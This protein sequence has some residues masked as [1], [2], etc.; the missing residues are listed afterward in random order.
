MAPH[1]KEIT[2][3]LTERRFQL[4]TKAG[5]LGLS[6]TAEGVSLAGVPLL[7]KTIAGLAPR[8]MDELAVLIKSAYGH[9]VDPTRPYPGLDVIAQALNKGD[10]GRAMVAAIHLR[11]PDLN[12]EG[13]A[14][15]ACA[16]EALNKYD[17]NELRDERGR[18]TTGGGSVPNNS[19]KPAA[20]KRP[21]KPT[22]PTRLARRPID[23]GPAGMRPILVSDP[24]GPSGVTPIGSLLVNMTLSRQC[25][26]NARDPNYYK[27]TQACAA[28]MEQCGW[29]LEANGK[30]SLRRDACVWPDGSAAIMKFGVLVPFKLGHSF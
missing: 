30:N 1:H 9:D 23:F 6:C 24:V 17:P 16:E 10:I 22:K 8:P 20:R 19:A 11:L 13:A 25:V 27:K 3:V 18:W 14:Q 21:A 28:V 15:I 26:H 4:E 5:G 7:R 29:L 12:E 2:L